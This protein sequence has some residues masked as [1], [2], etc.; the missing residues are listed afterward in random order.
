MRQSDTTLL[1]NETIS[2]WLRKTQQ[3]LH[4]ICKEAANK[5]REFLTTL[6]QAAHHTKIVKCKK[7][8]MGLKHA[9]E[10]C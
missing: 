9:K 7:L 5:C 1:M 6:I 10:N 3:K 2:S 8:I 4:T